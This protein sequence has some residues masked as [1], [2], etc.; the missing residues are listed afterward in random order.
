MEKMI[1]ASYLSASKNKISEL[2]V[3]AQRYITG[4]Q[5]SFSK[6]RISIAS[7]VTNLE[8]SMLRI[9]KQLTP[10]EAIKLRQLSQ[11]ELFLVNLKDAQFLWEDL[12]ARPANNTFIYE[13]L[14]K[15]SPYFRTLLNKDLGPLLLPSFRGLQNLE[16]FRYTKYNRAQK[17]RK[18]FLEIVLLTS[19]TDAKEVGLS[20]ATG[21]EKAS[22]EELNFTLAKNKKDKILLALAAF[23]YNKKAAYKSVEETLLKSKEGFITNTGLL[24]TEDLIA[25]FSAVSKEEIST[26]FEF[27]ETNTPCQ[28]IE[29]A[30]ENSRANNAEE[31]L[32]FFT[33]RAYNSRYGVDIKVVMALGKADTLV[34]EVSAK[35]IKEEVYSI[36]EGAY[37]TILKRNKSFSEAVFL[38]I[39]NKL[40]E[41]QLV[42][43]LDNL[44]QMTNFGLAIYE[45]VKTKIFLSNV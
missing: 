38:K 4:K 15:A 2:Y 7:P 10:T 19:S 16:P 22:L 39:A 6:Y 24:F 17:I 44:E 41:E 37:Q 33:T 13:D 14:S 9:T 12:Q 43:W 11:K 28:L 1:K 3:Q 40:V 8:T 35:S 31:N 42:P 21:R 5:Q 18:K 29:N 20:F 23:F 36:L 26:N 30:P 25:L 27:S 45:Q 34:L 32:G